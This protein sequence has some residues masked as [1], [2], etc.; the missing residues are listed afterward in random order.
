LEFK[1]KTKLKENY[2]SKAEPDIKINSFSLEQSCE[3]LDENL[4]V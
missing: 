3:L 2:L 1:D 4:F